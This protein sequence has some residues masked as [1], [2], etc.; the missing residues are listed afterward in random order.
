MVTRKGVARDNINQ[1]VKSKLSPQRQVGLNFA[2]EERWDGT[3][4]CFQVS[5]G[6][7]LDGP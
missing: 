5:K 6:A 3:L 4:Q 2:G 7:H 1:E